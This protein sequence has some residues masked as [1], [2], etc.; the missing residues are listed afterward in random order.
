MESL[1]NANLSL[2]HLNSYNLTA[3]VLTNASLRHVDLT[4]TF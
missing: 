3:A 4:G 2:T 1:L